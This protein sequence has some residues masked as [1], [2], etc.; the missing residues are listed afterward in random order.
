MFERHTIKQ[1]RPIDFYGPQRMINARIAQECPQ[2][3]IGIDG[4]EITVWL[5]L[6]SKINL[7]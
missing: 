5:S 1:M 3:M 2:F 7:C 4:N 6:I